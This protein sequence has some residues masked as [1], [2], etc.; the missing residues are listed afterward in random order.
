MRHHSFEDLSVHSRDLESILLPLRVECLGVLQVAVLRTV[1]AHQRQASNIGYCLSTG[2]MRGGTSMLADHLLPIKDLH[3]V[4]KLHAPWPGNTH[5]LVRAQS[6][7]PRHWSGTLKMLK[8]ALALNLSHQ[9]HSM[10]CSQM[11]QCCHLDCG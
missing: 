9:G 10:V 2:C 3:S 1:P 4:G 8:Q 6:G 11:G 7:T 5:H